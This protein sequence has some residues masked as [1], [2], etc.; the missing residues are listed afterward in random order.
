MVLFA[1]LGH[2]DL[3]GPVDLRDH[4]QRVR[5]EFDVD[6]PQIADGGVH[7]NTIGALAKIRNRRIDALTS[8]GRKRHQIV[9]RWRYLTADET[10]TA[11]LRNITTAVLS[12]SS[13]MPTTL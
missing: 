4:A 8:I 11:I 2:G 9:R 10:E 7:A 6:E 3:H 13:C 1:Q 5:I 12:T